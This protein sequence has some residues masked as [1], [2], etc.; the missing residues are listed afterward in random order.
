M[1]EILLRFS[2][3]GRAIFNEL[4]GRDFCTSRE[5]T[6]SWD[7][8][9]SNDRVLQ[10]AYKNRI[11]DNIQTLT[12][13]ADGYETT[14]FHLAAERGYFPVCRQIIENILNNLLTHHQNLN[15]DCNHPR[16]GCGWTPLH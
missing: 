9:I 6:Q 2:H 3:I 1:E 14:P 11:Q 16:D 4:D 10:R 15:A 12:E 13:E 8:F 5:V 7:L